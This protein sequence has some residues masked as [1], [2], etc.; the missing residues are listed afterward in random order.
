MEAH[1]VT[2]SQSRSGGV[3]SRTI[4]LNMY[5][6]RWCTRDGLAVRSPIPWW[7]GRQL[8][9][10]LPK[11]LQGVFRNKLRPPEVIT[12]RS[13]K[14]YT[15]TIGYIQLKFK[16]VFDDDEFHLIVHGR[17]ILFHDLEDQLFE[18]DYESCVIVSYHLC[19]IFSVIHNDL[20]YTFVVA[21]GRFSQI[22]PA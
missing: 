12:S 20:Q 8:L 6:G 1:E 18:F 17:R 15:E 7:Y 10:V 21:G 5:L 9:R 2:V 14:P 4:R 13:F 19:F 11:K 3:F 22:D 16:E